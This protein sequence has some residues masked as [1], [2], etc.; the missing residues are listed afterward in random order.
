MHRY[1]LVLYP[2]DSKINKNY[3]EPHRFHE[4]YCC[5]VMMTT[6]LYSP[7]LS[8]ACDLFLLLPICWVF[9]FVTKMNKWILSIFIRM[10]GRLFIFWLERASKHSAHL[11][12]CRNTAPFASLQILRSCYFYVFNPCCV[13]FIGWAQF[14]PIYSNMEGITNVKISQCHTNK[15]IRRNKYIIHTYTRDLLLSVNPW[16]DKVGW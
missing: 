16:T 3:F 14:I 15:I 11:K 1:T 5:I 12:N 13:N 7:S 8:E 9:I 4:S 6:H 2:I 10:M